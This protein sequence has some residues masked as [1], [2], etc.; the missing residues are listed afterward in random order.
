[1]KKIEIIII[2]AGLYVCGKGTDGFGTILPA[3]F[4]WSRSNQHIGNIKCVS[5]SSQ[6]SKEIYHK[7]KQLEVKTGVKLD[8]GCY[9]KNGSQKYYEHQRNFADP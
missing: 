5:T 2:G 6:S 9:P 4:E 3:I 7:A 1:M 8:I